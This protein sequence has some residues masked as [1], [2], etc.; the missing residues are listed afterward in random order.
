MIYHFQIFGSACGSA[1]L[2]CG[3][4]LARAEPAVSLYTELVVYYGTKNYLKRVFSTLIQEW[5]ESF[6]EYS[7][8]AI[9]SRNF[10]QYCQSSQI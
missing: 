1:C 6:N 3:G 4:K 7:Y 2:V 9:M 5:T 10:V 8:S